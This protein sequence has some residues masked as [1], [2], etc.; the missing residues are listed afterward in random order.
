MRKQFALLNILIFSFGFA[1]AQSTFFRIYESPEYNTMYSVSETTGNDFILCGFKETY[2]GSSFINAQLLKIDSQGNVLQERLLESDTIQSS[3][4][5]LRKTIAGEDGFFLTGRKDSVSGDSIFHLLKL[6]KLDE[7]L[8]FLN[9]YSL[10]FADSLINFPQQ[11]VNL[12]DSIIYILSGYFRPPATKSDFSLIKYNLFTDTFTDFFPSINTLRVASNLAFDT[13]GQQLKVL[14]AGAS[15]KDRGFLRILSF[16]MDLNYISEFEPDFN[17]SSITCRLSNYYNDSYIISG[18]ILK[19]SGE[20]GLHNLVFNNNNELIDSITLFMSADTLTYPGSG[21]S[22]LVAD[23]SIWS[24]GIYNIDPRTLWQSD[25]TWIQLSKLNAD[26]ELTDQFYYGGD[27]SY[28][29]FDIIS[30]TDGGILVTGNYYNPNAVPLVYQRDPFVLKVNKDG[31]IVNINNPP[32]PIA[33]EA[34]VLPNPGNEFLQVKLAIQH[35]AAHIQLYDINGRFVLESDLIGDLHKVSTSSLVTGTYIYR[36][37][38]SN[39]VIGSGKW[40]KQ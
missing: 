31:L 38:A 21:N 1:R 32:Q 25:P 6:W 17:F 37:T 22:I 11:F 35:K 4:A 12:N 29:P 3:F 8:N 15:L 39:R 40:V 14:I 30:T 13:T 18:N 9:E 7:S 28:N 23:S 36:I 33:Q 27:G 34:I 16:D 19:S 2:P 20:T 10:N 24:V 26:F 5:T